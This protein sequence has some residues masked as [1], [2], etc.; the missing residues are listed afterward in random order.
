[1]TSPSELFERFRQNLSVSNADEISTKYRNITKRLNLDFW[2][3][4]SET[5][6]SLQIGSYGRR[7]AIDGI[8]DLDMVFELPADCLSRYRKLSGNGPSAML[9]EVRASLLKRYNASDIRADGQVVGVNFSGYRVEVL[10]AFLDDNGDYIHGDTNNGGSW[11][12]TKPRPEISAVNALSKRSGSVYKDA[13]RM[14]RAWKNKVGVGIGGLLIDTL[15]YNFFDSNVDFDGCGYGDYPEM[16]VSLFAYLGGLEEQQ[17]WLAPGSNQRVRCKANFQAKARKAARRCQEALDAESTNLQIRLW[18]KVF[19]RQFP[20]A[21]SVAKADSTVVGDALDPEQFIEDMF[22][23][24]VRYDLE[25]DCEI[26]KETMSQQLRRLLAQ[27]KRISTGRSLRFFVSR[28][29]VVGDYFLYWKVRN[30]GE[31]AR[32]RSQLRGQI[33]LDKGRGERTETADFDGNHYVEAYIVQNGICVA[34]DR[35]PVPITSGGG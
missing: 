29:N 23:V 27:R 2:D 6:N 3:R 35:I 24:D 32:R 31:I 30:R 15:I 25:L 33:E 11:K 10:P 21:E 28:T 14:L 22:P 34:R 19:G 13:C 8:S 26:V 12:L 7:T 1:M 18:R 16:L 17:Y 5:L 9:Q 20:Q 4:E